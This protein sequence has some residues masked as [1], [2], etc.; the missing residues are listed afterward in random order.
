MSCR[1]LVASYPELPQSVA[2]VHVRY[3]ANGREHPLDISI[4]IQDQVEDGHAVVVDMPGPR[5]T[6]GGDR[7]H[8]YYLAIL[9]RDVLPQ[10]RC[11]QEQCLYHTSIGDPGQSP[12]P[13]SSAPVASLRCYVSKPP[14]ARH[15]TS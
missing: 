4:R 10:R 14:N 7:R 13:L 2:E 6:V 9:I 8:D 12:S 3:H 1:P 5:G 11:A 15:K